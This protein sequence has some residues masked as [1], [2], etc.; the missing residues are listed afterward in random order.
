MSKSDQLKIKQKTPT[1]ATVKGLKEVC[2]NKKIPLEKRQDKWR[3][4]KE[5]FGAAGCKG[6]PYP[7]A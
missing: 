3:T 2:S 5:A 6:V 4:V 1:V 7:K